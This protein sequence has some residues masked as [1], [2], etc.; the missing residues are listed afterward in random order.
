MCKTLKVKT[1]FKENLRQVEIKFINF[2]KFKFSKHSYSNKN[3]K[4]TPID[5]FSSQSRFK[6]N[7]KRW[8]WYQKTK[9]WKNFHFQFKEKNFQANFQSIAIPNFQSG[10]K[11][12]I[13]TCEHPINFFPS[14]S[15]FT[16]NQR[17]RLWYQKKTEK[18]FKE[19]KFQVKLN[20]E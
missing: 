16:E 3:E 20:F 5:F 1:I 13:S 7:Q 14:Q 9:N 11:N 19:G 15:R 12:E 18:F 10:S 17:G 8:L 6:E 2:L 4:S